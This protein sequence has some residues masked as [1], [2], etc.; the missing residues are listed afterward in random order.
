MK[1]VAVLFLISL[2]VVSACKRERPLGDLVGQWNDT[3]EDELR[4]VQFTADG[5][6]ELIE[7]ECTGLFQVWYCAGPGDWYTTPDVAYVDDQVELTL[8][9]DGDEEDTGTHTEER[10]LLYESED[11][12][13]VEQDVNF[14]RRCFERAN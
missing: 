5:R 6:W 13:C 7:G 8:S 4:T 3:L 9:Y 1:R 11:R 12:I 14:G 2:G 10:A